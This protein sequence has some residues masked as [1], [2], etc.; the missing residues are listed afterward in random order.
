MFHFKSLEGSL[1]ESS[2]IQPVTKLDLPQGVQ[3]ESHLCNP[4]IWQCPLK[5]TDLGHVNCQWEMDKL[6]VS[7]DD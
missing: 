7:R 4:A 5:L 1:E 2:M 6:E 3:L